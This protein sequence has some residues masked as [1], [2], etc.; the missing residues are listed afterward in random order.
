MI[1]SDV[2]FPITEAPSGG[3]GDAASDDEWMAPIDAAFGAAQ[4]TPM[5]IRTGQPEQDDVDSGPLTL[6]LCQSRILLLFLIRLLRQSSQL[7]QPTRAPTRQTVQ[8]T[9]APRRQRQPE[10]SASWT[11]SRPGAAAPREGP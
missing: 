7:S 4:R 3:S 2:G 10:Q 9:A 11:A 8:S 6:T 1:T 5:T